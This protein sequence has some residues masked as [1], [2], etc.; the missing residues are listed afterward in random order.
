L[1]QDVSAFPERLRVRVLDRGNTASTDA[2]QPAGILAFSANIFASA[3][4]QAPEVSGTDPLTREP[5]GKP[6]T[7]CRDGI[8]QFVGDGFKV[9][10]EGLLFSAGH[11][12]DPE[13]LPT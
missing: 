9:A 2:P 6:D 7:V 11:T 5:L 12:V 3:S 10:A 13:E 1:F 8:Q 4:I